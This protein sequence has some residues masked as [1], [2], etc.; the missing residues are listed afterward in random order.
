MIG[1]GRQSRSASFQSFMYVNEM[2]KV[3]WMCVSVRVYV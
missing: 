3:V 2:G 1:V